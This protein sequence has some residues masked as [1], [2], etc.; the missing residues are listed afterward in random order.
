M[1]AVR[2]GLV[3][4]EG[5]RLF[6][7]YGKMN[8][9]GMTMRFCVLA[10]TALAGCT[11]VTNYYFGPDMSTDAS[12]DMSQIQQTGNDLSNAPDMLVSADLSKP[13]DLL[14][15]VDLSK[16]ADMSTTFD[17]ALTPD[18][19][20][21]PDLASQPDLTPACVPTGGTCKTPSDTC[22]GP[23]TCG[24]KDG[25]TYVCCSA[26]GG[27]CD[28]DGDCCP[29]PGKVVVCLSHSCTYHS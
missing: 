22:C 2:I 14:M 17:L 5:L 29:V 4:L 20:Q 26:P 21:V 1:D 8:D 3:P 12:I 16:A 18:L 9:G 13:A 11:S 28:V 24:S 15:S 10:V 23:T 25:I 27:P 7:N 19:A 6:A